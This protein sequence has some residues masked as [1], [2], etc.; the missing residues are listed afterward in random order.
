LRRA[1]L[2]LKL[3]SEVGFLSLRSDGLHKVPSIGCYLGAGLRDDMTTKGRIARFH[4]PLSAFTFGFENALLMFSYALVFGHIRIGNPVRLD[5]DVADTLSVCDM[6]S[7]FCVSVGAKI[8]GAAQRRCFLF[9][10]NHLL[11]L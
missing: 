4:C 11:L 3:L 8:L 9:C 5:Y 1:A 2:V 6:A 7:A 10:S